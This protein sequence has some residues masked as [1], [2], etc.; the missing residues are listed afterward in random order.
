MGPELSSTWKDGSD[1]YFECRLVQIT[2]VY[3]SRNLH[4]FNYII[5]IFLCKF[6]LELN[7]KTTDNNTHL[8]LCEMQMLKQL[9]LLYNVR[10]EIQHSFS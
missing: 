2:V 4:L 6:G 8:N 9:V 1:K 10:M 7:K 5:V 3:V